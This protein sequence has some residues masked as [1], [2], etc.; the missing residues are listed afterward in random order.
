VAF[1]TQLQIV[2]SYG[3]SGPHGDGADAHVADLLQRTVEGQ[4]KA[5]QAYVSASAAHNVSG[6][7][8][9]QADL[10]VMSLLY[11]YRLAILRWRMATVFLDS[12]VVA[13]KDQSAL[14]TDVYSMGDS[15]CDDARRASRDAV[16]S[17]TQYAAGSKVR[18]VSIDTF[19]VPTLTASKLPGVWA[20]FQVILAV[21]EKELAQWERQPIPDRFKALIERK[22]A[23][24]RPHLEALRYLSS[25]WRT[26]RIIENQ[27]ELLREATGHV[28]SLYETVQHLWAPYLIGNDFN[29]VYKQ[30]PKLSELSVANPWILTDPKQLQVH[31]G[32]AASEAELAEFWEALRDPEGVVK[33]AE[34]VNS[35]VGSHHLRRRVA[36]GYKI[37]PWPSQFLVRHSFDVGGTTFAPGEL[38]ALYASQDAAG[39]FDVSLR[40]TGRVI[41][42]LEWF[43]IR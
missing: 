34:R 9:L 41:H 18:L 2:A 23:Q 14:A 33:L 37:L 21:A 13:S 22:L 17:A 39:K 29:V 27:V 26:S 7:K 10:S 30:K 25:E 4:W 28:V 42:I 32:N 3:H 19:S 6:P 43:G 15:L 24:A 20:I 11:R 8:L 31:K 16:E 36:N 38:V 1:V 5:S 35:L 40:R 12:G